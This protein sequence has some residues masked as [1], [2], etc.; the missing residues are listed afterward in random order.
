MPPRT[1]KPFDRPLVARIAGDSF[2]TVQD[3]V[4][5]HLPNPVQQRARV[6]QHDPRLFAFVDQLRDEFPHPLIAPME[7]RSVVII[8][9]ALVIHHILQVTDDF[10]GAQVVASGRNQRLVHVQGDRESALDVAEIDST[11]RQV[12]RPV[13]AAADR[14]FNHGFGPADV[15]SLL[16]VLR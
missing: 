9:D 4:E 5:S 8:A 12:S 6:F 10:G 13:L 11:L 14:R 1:P 15:G 7:H 16:N 3:V 2:E